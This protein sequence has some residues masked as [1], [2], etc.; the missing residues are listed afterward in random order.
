[1]KIEAI[2]LFYERAILQNFGRKVI[3]LGYDKKGVDG[4][5]TEIAREKMQLTLLSEFPLGETFK[6]YLWL[7]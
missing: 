1:M 7:Y 4:I 6:K 3:P 5:R 2:F